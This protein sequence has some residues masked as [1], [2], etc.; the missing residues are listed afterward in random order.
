MPVLEVPREL[1][2]T[3]SLYSLL[4]V[5][6]CVRD[7]RA[8]VV[9]SVLRAKGVARCPKPHPLRRRLG[10][11]CS[12]VDCAVGLGQ[13]GMC[14][15][16]LSGHMTYIISHVTITYPWSGLQCYCFIH[17]AAAL[18]VRAKVRWRVRCALEPGE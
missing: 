16:L 12:P 10:A 2:L 6:L 7:L 18:H 14:W 5:S 9:C 3:L 15:Q 1:D 17:N 11:A 13:R 8:V 4:E